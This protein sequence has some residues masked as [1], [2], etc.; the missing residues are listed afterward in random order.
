MVFPVPGTPLKSMPLGALIPCCCASFEQERVTYGKE[1]ESGG[2][3]TFDVG[4]VVAHG[5]GGGGGGCDCR[6]C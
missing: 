5:G 2:S 4:V 6:W 3:A 1:R